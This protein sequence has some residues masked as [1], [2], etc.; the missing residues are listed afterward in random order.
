MKTLDIGINIHATNLQI[1]L[2]GS[3]IN[4]VGL[5]VLRA[6]SLVRAI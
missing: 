1:A 3:V 4:L 6:T 2:P 5:L